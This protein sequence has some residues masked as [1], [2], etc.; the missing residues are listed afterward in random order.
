MDPRV[1]RCARD[2]S[3]AEDEAV[4]SVDMVRPRSMGVRGVTGSVATECAD[5]VD[6]RRKI[7]WEKCLPGDAVCGGVW[8][9]RMLVGDVDTRP[10]GGD[11]ESWACAASDETL[12]GA[13]CPWPKDWPRMSGCGRSAWSATNERVDDGRTLCV[14]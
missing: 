13:R 10:D 3:A 12:S 9:V 14:W 1:G 8:T 5:E 11:E 4:E 2:E 7:A 6:G